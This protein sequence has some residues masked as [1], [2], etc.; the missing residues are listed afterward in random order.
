M[1]GTGGAA[2]FSAAPLWKAA[3]EKGLRTGRRSENPLY[4]KKGVEAML[5]FRMRTFLAV[6]RCLNY[7]RA[8]EKLNIT[9]PAVTQHIQYLQE[10]YGV[11]LLST[12]TSSLP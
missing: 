1:R 2:L 12:A 10:Y 11:K 9:Q 5:D 7:T 8:A 4:W 3:A 6:C